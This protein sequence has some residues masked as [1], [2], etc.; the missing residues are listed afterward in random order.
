[1]RRLATTSL[2]P[3]PTDVGELA[4]AKS[5]RLIAR[6]IAAGRLRT[7]CTG[8][9]HIPLTGPA[10][11][12]ARHYH[13]LFDG[14]ALFAAIQRQFHIVVTLDW[15]QTYA[16][17]LLMTQLTRLAHWPVILRPD[18]LLRKK[19]HWA[20]RSRHAFS[21][22][23]VEHFQHRALRESV[24][25]LENHR[26]LVVFPEGYPNI[27]P[28]YTPKT[29]NGC[30]LP[31]KRGFVTI[32]RATERRLGTSL[33]I[34]PTGLRYTAGKPWIVDVRFSQAVKRES[35]ASDRDLICYCE[36]KVKQLSS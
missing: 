17:R 1:M 30:F 3:P 32:A 12:V 11:I 31:F 33:P 27:D 24:R 2:I 14:L 6:G 28:T 20:S 23:D 36:N 35:F 21:I 22:R 18:A 5:M 10:L 19:D 29:D 4:T 26:L 13:H 15:V 8:S 25:L 9:E 7:V 34:I 16:M